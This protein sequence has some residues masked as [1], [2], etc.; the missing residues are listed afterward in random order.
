MTTKQAIEFFGG[1]RALA[2]ALGVSTQ[3]IY[4]WGE[5]PPR[6]RQCEIQVLTNGALRA[7]LGVQ[8]A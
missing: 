6:Q 1:A 4:Q 2:A 7:D 8:N 3:S 5:R